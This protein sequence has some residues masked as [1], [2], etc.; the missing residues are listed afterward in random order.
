MNTKD[1]FETW[2]GFFAKRE[3]FEQ[4][5]QVAK[6]MHIREKEVGQIDK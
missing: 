1:I 3:S 4:M 2:L 5:I 6:V